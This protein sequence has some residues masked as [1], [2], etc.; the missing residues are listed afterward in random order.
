MRVLSFRSW[1]GLLAIAGGLVPFAAPAAA[2]QQQLTGQV[3]DA[4][5]RP[6]AGLEVVLHRVTE[7]GGTIVASDT[8]DTEGAFTLRS[9]DDPPD[10]V[11]FV[12]A[13]YEG[14]LHIG[15]MLR[16]PFPAGEYV[17]RVGGD[18]VT[19]PVETPVRPVA[20]SRR[21]AIALMVMVG[22][23]GLGVFGF[24]RAARPSARRRL[25]LRLAQ[26][27]ETRDADGRMDAAAEMERSRILARLRFGSSA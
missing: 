5:E 25:L 24:V 11:Y 4:E 27:E 10:A 3:L 6:V 23:L 12:A 14:Q 19:A 15:S 26:L 2:Q 20:G 17:L 21:P 13:R 16:A 22:L 7:G 1:T 8:S 18:P 9:G